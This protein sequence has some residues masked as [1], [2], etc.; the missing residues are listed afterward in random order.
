MVRTAQSVKVD[1]ENTLIVNGA[2]S[3]MLLKAG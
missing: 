3:L 1:K 2:A